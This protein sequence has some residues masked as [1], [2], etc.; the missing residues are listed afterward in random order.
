MP[1]P[2]P[3]PSP[4]PLAL[5][6]TPPRTPLPLPPIDIVAP[7]TGAGSN[8]LSRGGDGEEIEFPGE[9]PPRPASN[10]NPPSSPSSISR[11]LR[12]DDEGLSSHEKRGI[13]ERR[14]SFG[15]EVE[16]EAATLIELVKDKIYIR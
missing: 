11:E 14:F 3:F 8:G 13:Q 16:V 7:A 10:N 15:F 12:G 5:A 6:P 9:R 4:P 2:F 1:I